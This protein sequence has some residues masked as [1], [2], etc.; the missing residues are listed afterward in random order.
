MLAGL[1]VQHCAVVASFGGCGSRR[2]LRFA[3]QLLQTLGGNYVNISRNTLMA[4]D[5]E[6]MKS[7]EW[8]SVLQ[9]GGNQVRV[10]HS[11]KKNATLY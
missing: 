8:I 2:N 6:R 5:Q 10:T 9:D 1:K 3:V 11:A 7:E 4:E